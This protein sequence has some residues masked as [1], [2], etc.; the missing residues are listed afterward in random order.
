MT[1]Q[2]VETGFA[3][4]AMPASAA[5]EPS[6]P[7]AEKSIPENTAFA[8]DPAPAEPHP[9]GP[10]VAEQLAAKYMAQGDSAETAAERA[11]AEPIKLDPVHLHTAGVTRVIVADDPNV[12]AQLTEE[13]LRARQGE[14]H[15]AHTNREV[16]ERILASRNAPPAVQIPQP[17]AKRITDQT[18]AEMKEGARIS[19]IHAERSRTIP[20][21]QPSQR[22]VAAQGT[23]TPV[24][25]P[26]DFV[27]DPTRNQGDVRAQ[28]VTW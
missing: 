11:F 7:V 14:S 1:E 2:L 3:D 24:F 8:P 12:V 13:E 10:T 16:Y 26:A 6:E 19:A 21:S 9:N 22:E 20:R 28:P 23:T 27:P 17:V 25:R 18:T 15:A 5:A 4:L